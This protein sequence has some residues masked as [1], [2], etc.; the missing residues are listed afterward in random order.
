MATDGRQLFYNPSYVCNV[1]TPA[2]L[3]GDL[4]HEALHCMCAHFARRG[5]RD[6]ERFN[7]AADMAIDPLAADA[8]YEQVPGSVFPA[9]HGLPNGET[10]EWYYSH[11][12][13]GAGKGRGMGPGGVLTP[14]NQHGAPDPQAAQALAADWQVA[15][16]QAAVRASARG[17]LPGG[18]ALLVGEL[19]QPRVDWQSELRDFLTLFSRD[20]YCWSVPSRMGL[21]LGMIL[22]GMRSER[23]GPLV[24]LVDNSGSIGRE[25]L[26]MFSSEVAAVIERNP[27]QVTVLHHDVPVTHR[28]DWSPDDGD[29]QL[30]PKG[31]GGTSHVPA[32]AEVDAMDDAP[33]AVI[34]LTDLYSDFPDV[35]PPYPV[36][37]VAPEGTGDGP[38]W[39]RLVRVPV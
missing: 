35:P 31:G 21:A 15:T 30:E 10:A 3:I 29:L 7:L 34:A 5:D 9:Q 14:K 19:T 37:W 36:L 8:G 20:D 2:Q 1:L 25:L 22:P 6:P 39:G 16:H 38:G 33:A 11:L 23:L 24:I 28:Q 27:A 4:V 17:N 32:F 12:P 13:Q 18:L 26:T